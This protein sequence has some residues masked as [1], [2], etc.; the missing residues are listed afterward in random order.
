MSTSLLIN[1]FIN[2]ELKFNHFIKTFSDIFN[3]FDEIH[4]KVRG[5][6]KHDCLKFVR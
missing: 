4:I 2:N 5:L 3:I 1:V 6:Y